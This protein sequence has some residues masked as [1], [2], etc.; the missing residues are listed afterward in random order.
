MRDT[1]GLSVS[2]PSGAGEARRVASALAERAG[3]DEV[4]RGRV[5][6]VATELAANLVLHA[7]SGELVISI[8]PGSGGV[9]QGIEVLSLD[10]G[11]GMADF[12]RC[13]ADGYSTSGTPGNG[14][15]AVSRAADSFEVHTAT[16]KGSALLA[17]FWPSSPPPDADLGLEFGAVCLPMVGERECGDAWLAIEQGPGL[18]I[19][20]VADG[21]GHGP[22][23]AEASNAAIQSFRRSSDKAPAEILLEA[24]QALKGTRGAAVAIARVDR[25]RRELRFSGM[26][27]IAATI[28]GPDTRQG[29]VSHSGIVGVEIR[30]PQEFTQ[31]WPEGAL[32][33]M[34]SDGLTSHWSL[35]RRSPL[36]AKHPAL[37]AGVLY[38]DYARERDDSTVVVARD[39]PGRP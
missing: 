29:L 23:A 21:L 36:A 26:G 4:G 38:R 15:G 2:E 17:R 3:F 39:R 13:L 19:V 12:L 8:V 27:N 31:P 28:L 11:G 30:K 10:K 34:H 25:D 33:V 20:I 32:L 37:V 6:L 14:L 7:G 22:A 35:E 18:T 24:H 9:G 1:V 16:G 5:A